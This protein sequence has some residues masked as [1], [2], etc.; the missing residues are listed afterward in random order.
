MPKI[1]KYYAVAK[2]RATG[3]YNTWSDCSTQ[4]A[5]YQGAKYKSFKSME[6]ALYFVEQHKTEKTKKNIPNT[7]DIDEHDNTNNQKYA[8]VVYKKVYTDGSCIGNGKKNS[9]AGI[10]CFFGD[11]DPMNHSSKLEGKC[12]NQTAELKAIIAALKILENENYVEVLTDS[13]YAVKAMTIWR[14]GWEKNNWLTA[15]KKPVQNLEIFKELIKEVNKKIDV[16]FTHVRGHSNIHGN[17]M[18][19]K[20]AK[21][22]AYSKKQK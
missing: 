8:S 3:I 19:D 22:G 20:L 5:S 12:T 21:A 4:V 14:F 7:K 16:K 6:D 15:S 17:E 10:G 1:T 2:G 9:F 13:E 18:A 11:N